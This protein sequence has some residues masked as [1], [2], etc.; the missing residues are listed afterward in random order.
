M[1]AALT[2][3]DLFTVNTRYINS[4]SFTEQQEFSGFIPTE[5]DKAIMRDTTYYRVMDVAGFG[6]ARSSY[7]HK[8][9]GGYHAAKLTRYNDLLTA[10]LQGKEQLNMGVLNMLNAKYFILPEGK[11]EM[12]PDAMGNA[13]FVDR[14]DY[15][16]GAAAEM[17]GLDSLD[18]A[19]NAV[20]DDTFRKVLGNSQPKSAGDTITLAY[21]SPDKL[22]YSANSAKG[23]VAVFSE[24]YFPDGWQA[25]IDGKPAEIGRVNYVLRALNIPAGKHHVEFTFAP[26]GVESTNTV[27]VISV[28]AVYL[29][30]AAAI[31]VCVVAYMRRRKTQEVKK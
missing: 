3:I 30:C 1:V 23:G 4:D 26:K 2:L 21:Y 14:V 16:K 19:R 10:Q 12:N 29:F 24:V 25:T 28:I 11:Y 13:W 27:S 17:K 8:T 18:V 20:A 6:D 9:I 31:A 7:F 15:V 22:S 5:A